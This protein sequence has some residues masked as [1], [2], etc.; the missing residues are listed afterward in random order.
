MPKPT[1]MNY[2]TKLKEI[3]AVILD[4]DGVLTDGNVILLPDGS[5]TRTMNTRDGYA[6]QLAIKKGIQICI[7][8]GGKDES[9]KSRLNY[10]GLTDVYLGSHNKIEDFEDF[11]F[12]YGLDET[13]IMYMGDDI[14]DLEVMQRV[15]L[16]C[17]PRNAAPEI[18]KISDY[19]SQIDGGKGCVRDILEQL[20]KV[21]GKWNE[22]L[23]VTST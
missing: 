13:Q 3:K 1:T 12:K 2:K 22:D 23:G 17:C 15:G 18:Q 4:V 11:K 8:T 9:V 19:I 7:I 6:M 16:P 20:L 21:Q 5:M 14:P 10:L